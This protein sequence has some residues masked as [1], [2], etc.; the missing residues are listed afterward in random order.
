MPD[1][2]IKWS[3]TTIALTRKG[4]VICEW[5]AEELGVVSKKIFTAYCFMI[6]DLSVYRLQVIDD[7]GGQDDD[8]TLRLTFIEK[9]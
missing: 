6:A 2:V 3:R 9:A 4:Y 7:H 1:D 8:G 5:D